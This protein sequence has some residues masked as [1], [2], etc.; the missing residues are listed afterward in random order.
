MTTARTI[1]R[2]TAR[3]PSTA[4]TAGPTIF[5]ESDVSPKPGC[6][7]TRVVNTQFEYQLPNKTVERLLPL[8]VVG[9]SFD[10][11]EIVTG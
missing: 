6:V 8:V 9:T 4:P 10:V 7:V 11:D 2:T 1:S 5:G 3:T